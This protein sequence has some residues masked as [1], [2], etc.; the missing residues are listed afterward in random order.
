MNSMYSYRP[1]GEETFPMYETKQPV[2][3]LVGPGLGFHDLAAIDDRNLRVILRALNDAFLAGK[4]AR[5]V[6]ICNL[7]GAKID[8]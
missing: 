6:E 3:R 1:L 2:T 5:S 4:R 8:R 7:L